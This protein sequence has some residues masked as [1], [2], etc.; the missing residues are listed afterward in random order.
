MKNEIK[1]K[2]ENKETREKLDILGLLDIAIAVQD[3][4]QEK[5]NKIIEEKG[6]KND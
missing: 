5:V 2:L 4:D 1:K 3:G 6:R